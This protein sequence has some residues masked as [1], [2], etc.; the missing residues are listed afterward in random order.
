MSDIIRNAKLFAEL[1]RRQQAV[2]GRAP[3]AK[4]APS[5]S[6]TRETESSPPSEGAQRERPSKRAANSA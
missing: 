5:S 2:Q 4:D 6:A 3:V 1:A